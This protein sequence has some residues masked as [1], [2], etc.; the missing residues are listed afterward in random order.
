MA[1]KILRTASASL[2]GALVAAGVA[3]GYATVLHREFYALA[4]GER[5]RP[6]STPS[7]DD[8]ARFREF[9]WQRASRD[10]GFAARWPTAQSFDSAAMKE[11]LALNPFKPVVGIDTV[12][13][14]ATGTELDVARA[15]SVNPD[16]DRR[17]QDRLFVQNG[18]VVLDPFGRAIPYDPR[19]TWFGG[20]SGGASQFDAHGATLRDKMSSSYITAFLHPERFS[21]EGVPLGSAPEFSQTY[22]DLALVAKLRGT[23]ADDWLALSFGA[24]NMHGIEDLGNQIHCTVIGNGHFLVDAIETWLAH[25]ITGLFSKSSKSTATAP[26]SLTPDQV[27]ATTISCDEGHC[28]EVDP[29]VLYA[30]NKEPGREPTLQDWGLQILAN[31]H[32]L[33]EDYFQHEYMEGIEA[34]R[35]GR[36]CR[37]E[38]KM[39]YD[40]ALAG[41]K[42]FRAACLAALAK[43]GYGLGKKPGETQFAKIISVVMID[44]S[45]PEASPIYAAIRSIAKKDL[46]RGGVYPADAVPPPEPR[47]YL[48][49]ARGEK[50]SD[51]DTIFELHA[52]AFARVVEALRLW[53]DLLDSETKD[54]PPGSDAADAEIQRVV[55]RLVARQLQYLGDAQSRRDTY[56]QEKQAEY[57]KEH[58]APAESGFTEALGRAPF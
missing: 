47:D 7:T 40:R 22:T 57:A 39:V 43:A 48:T 38:V 24:N 19:T 30:L 28:A 17:N 58:P 37:P 18:R 45:A 36:P 41:D 27:N 25:K 42:E 6:V 46:R 52:R 35:A 29:S 16:D 21:P 1:R 44:H 34:L 53:S 9:L 26:S 4:F 14:N 2:L 33:L 50:N 51:T 23:P 10:P 8:L 55:D 11:F 54:A 20:L 56:V 49:I 31:H 13:Q 32:R 3:Q 15:G 5:T 12:P